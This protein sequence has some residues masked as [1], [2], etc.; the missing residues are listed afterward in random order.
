M[1]LVIEDD[2]L[3][4]ACKDF[5]RSK[6]AEQL[7]TNDDVKRSDGWDGTFRMPKSSEPGN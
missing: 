4:G 3:A 5:L 6:R 1:A 2:N 7:V